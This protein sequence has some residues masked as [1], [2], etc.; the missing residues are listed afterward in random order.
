M[1]GQVEIRD[2]AGLRALT[3]LCALALAAAGLLATAL[4]AAPAWAGTGAAVSLTSPQ[5]KVDSGDPLRL[6]GAVKK[7]TKG[8]R[9]LLLAKPT[10]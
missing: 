1:T 3:P 5:A 2:R 9:V 6:K 4:H 7:W 10:G 8:Q